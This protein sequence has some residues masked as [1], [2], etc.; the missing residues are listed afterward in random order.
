VT[1][2]ATRSGLRMTADERKQAVLSV[3]V[4]LFARDGYGGTSTEAIAEAAGISQPYLFRLFGTKKQLFLETVAV[5]CKAVLET[6]ERVSVGLEGEAA[7]EAMGAAY[8]PLI[9]DRDLLLIQL[10]GYAASGDPDIRAFVS[11]RFRA[12]VE[13]VAHRTSLGPERVREFV[14]MGM[15]CN[16]IS[17][18]ELG[19]IDELF[20]DWSDQ[21][22]KAA[23]IAS[24]GDQ[25]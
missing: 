20:G 9:T 18:L 8:G 14:A 10:Q 19:S 4:R 23:F 21:P 16:V 1:K 17:A 7:L 25:H 12:I 2:T 11:G 22:E 15:L 6:F 5:G 3:A 24:L 13:F